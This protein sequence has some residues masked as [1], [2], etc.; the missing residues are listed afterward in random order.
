MRNPPGSDVVL[1]PVGPIEDRCR[2]SPRPVGDRSRMTSPTHPTAG[3][4]V[5][6]PLIGVTMDLV[7]DQAR[8]RRTYL[9]AIA[10]AGGI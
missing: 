9:R 3:V 2:T 10:A 4:P 7:D 8:L 5:S 1:S 6:R